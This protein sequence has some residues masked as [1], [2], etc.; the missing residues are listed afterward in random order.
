MWA[1]VGCLSTPSSNYVQ[2]VHH[3]LLGDA[4]Q[5]WCAK[6]TSFFIIVVKGEPMH[7]QVGAG[8]F[9]IVLLEEGFFD[10]IFFLWVASAGRVA[11]AQ[12]WSCP[13]SHSMEEVATLC[14]HR[15]EL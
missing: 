8:I 9:I 10:I 5:S 13:T 12:P 11:L 14:V 6:L 3:L 15:L 7:F 1:A 2:W 4:H